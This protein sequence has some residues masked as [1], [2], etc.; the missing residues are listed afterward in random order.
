[1]GTHVA[2]AA[3]GNEEAAMGGQPTGKLAR[4]SFRAGHAGQVERDV[5]A[6]SAAW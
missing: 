4:N 6:P 3:E 5:D 2:G 1:M